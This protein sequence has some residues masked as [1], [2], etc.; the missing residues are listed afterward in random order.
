VIAVLD[1]T[2]TAVLFPGQGSQTQGMRELVSATRPD[3]LAAVCELV[4]DDPFDRAAESTRY[5]QPAIFCTS[6]ARWTRI[7][8]RINPTVMAGHS[9]GELTALAAAGAVDELD[10]LALVVRR[11]ELMA[12]SGQASGDGTML[13]LIGSTPSRAAGLAARHRVFVAN[14]NAPDQVVLS[15]ERA[16]LDAAAASAARDGLGATTLAVTGA[17]HSPHMASAVTP[18][19]EALAGVE[20]RTPTVAVISCTTARRFV[21]PAAEL[22][23][24]LVAPV[25][26]RSTMAALSDGGANTFIDVGPGRG[27]AQLA[28]RCVAGVAAS[29]AETLETADVAA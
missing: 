21:D 27:L 20:F 12:D 19:R 29:T 16:D 25:R 24:A 3:L 6:L 2:R 18:F 26:W 1:S 22:A 7:A 13:A 4:G 9:L 23:D 28:R 15:G 5:A 14:D 17:F 11:A 10:A 8:D